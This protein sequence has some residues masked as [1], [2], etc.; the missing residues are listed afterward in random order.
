M[1]TTKQRL[2]EKIERI[3]DNVDDYDCSLAFENGA[4]LL[5]PLLL[6][7]VKA[8]HK[9]AN[10]NFAPNKAWATEVAQDAINKFEEFLK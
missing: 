7:M 6:D 9:V 8:L 1:T 4:N 10:G 3:S 2:G 5:A